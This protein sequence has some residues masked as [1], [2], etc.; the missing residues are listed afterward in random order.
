MGG[1]SEHAPTYLTNHSFNSFNWFNWF[2]SLNWSN[3]AALQPNIL[4]IRAQLDRG[5]LFF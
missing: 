3:S 2:N 4:L 5:V 1:S